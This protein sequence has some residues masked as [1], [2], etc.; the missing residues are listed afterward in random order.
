VGCQQPDVG[1]KCALDIAADGGVSFDPSTSSGDFLETGQAD[2]D[3]L[4]CIATAGKDKG[5]KGC[6]GG[7]CNPYCSKPCVS[8]KECF[9]AETG[10]VCRQLVLDP[11]FIKNLP[12]DKRQKYLGEVQFSSYCAVP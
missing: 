2:C 5:A 3:N 8:D 12:D 7:K 10:L 11:D 1:Q 4:V 6:S 9:H